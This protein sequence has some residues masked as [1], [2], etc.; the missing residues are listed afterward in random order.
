MYKGRQG[1]DLGSCVVN[2]AG[3]L[4]VCYRPVAPRGH[5]LQK[6]EVLGAF[7]ADVGDPSRPNPRW[8]D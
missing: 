5:L 6:R 2:G 1:Q 8:S 3:W 4:T 7:S